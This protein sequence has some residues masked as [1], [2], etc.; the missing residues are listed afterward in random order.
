MEIGNY[1]LGYRKMKRNIVL[2]MVAALGVLAL[3]LLVDVIHILV[4]QVPRS[5]W[6]LL[7]LLA[8]AY[9]FFYVANRGILRGK[10]PCVRFTTI[11]LGSALLAAVSFCL[12]WFVML[13]FHAWIMS[14]PSR[15][16]GRITDL[17]GNPIADARLAITPMSPET[18][19]R[20]ESETRSDAGGKF[21]L[22]AESGYNYLSVQADR[23]ASMGFVRMA[24][25]G[26]SRN[27]DFEL[28]RAVSISGRVLDTTG[29]PLPDR[30]VNFVPM[31]PR[32]IPAFKARF[33]KGWP[34][35]PTDT[36]GRFAITSAAPCLHKISVRSANTDMLQYPVNDRYIDMSSSNC[37]EPLEIIL[38][39]AKDYMI[40]GHVKSADGNP[41]P[42]V[43]VDTY[44]PSGPHWVDRTDGQGAF[45][46]QGL[47]GVGL[48]SFKVTFQGSH[49]GKDFDLTIDDVPMNSTNVTLVIPNRGTLCGTVRNAKTGNPVKV[50]EVSVHRVRWLDTGAVWEKPRVRIKCGS[51]GRFCISNLLAGEATVEIRAEG[52]GSQRFEIPVVAGTNPPMTFDMLGP[53]GLEINTTLNGIP[54]PV[55]ASIDGKMAPWGE[56]GH[57]QCDTCPNGK[58]QVRF[59]GSDGGSQQRAVEVE[60]R[61]GEITRLDMEMGGSCEVRGSVTYPDKYFYCMVRVASK[62]APDGWPSGGLTN[63]EDGVLCYSYVLRSGGEYRLRNIPPGRWHLMVGMDHRFIHRYTPVWTQVIELKDGEHL[64][65]DLTKM[66]GKK[67]EH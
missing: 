24:N 48:S 64:K 47:D 58:H 1:V 11:A 55:K 10:T 66:D 65:L 30:V 28:P 43:F 8:L 21:N 23:H 12:S 18:H 50:Y 15:V 67:L 29:K 38:H 31:I 33:T 9:V 37:A 25:L 20:Y 54:I 6:L 32:E 16:S 40:A 53:A 49:Q 36:D 4:H 57:S 35:T 7:V 56:N 3:L 41:I 13:F 26:W 44:I 5:W 39:P 52:L 63:P 61:S 51:D 46:I 59:F 45:R 34:P 22:R 62:P 19:S 27:W 17:L 60:L 14:I 2:N 42:H